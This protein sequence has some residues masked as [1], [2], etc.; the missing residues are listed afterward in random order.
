MVQKK[1]M[2]IYFNETNIIPKE[3][4]LNSFF[5]NDTNNN[6]YYRKKLLKAIIGIMKNLFQ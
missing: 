5:F 2:I 3:Y 1:I 6:L 4:N